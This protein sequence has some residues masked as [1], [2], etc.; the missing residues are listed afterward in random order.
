MLGVCECH[1][2]SVNMWTVWFLPITTGA[3]VL[4]SVTKLSFATVCTEVVTDELV[5][6]GCWWNY[7]GTVKPKHLDENL[8]HVT[9]FHH[10]WF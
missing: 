2:L 1:L 9:F 3:T 5:D 4:V 10:R 8:S 7:S 6:V